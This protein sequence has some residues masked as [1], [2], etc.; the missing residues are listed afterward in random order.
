MNL[1][2]IF[3]F[4]ATA[5][6]AVNII[7]TTAS[8]HN[9]T[10]C[11]LNHT[12]S[13]Q[14]WGLYESSIHW[15]SYQT[16]MT[17][18]CGDFTGKTF[19]T[20]ITGAVTAWDDAKFNNKDLMSMSVDNDSGCVIFLDK[21]ATQMA[22]TFGT[23]SWAVTY[24]T[25]AVDDGT[26]YNHYSTAAGNIE[27]WV[28]WTTLSGRSTNAKKHVPRHELGHVI[29]LI[30]VPSSVS[31]NGHIMCNGF[32]TQYTPPTTIS[33]EDLQGA[34]VILGQHQH[35][36]STIPYKYYDKTYCRKTCTICNARNRYKHTYKNNICMLCGYKKTS[37][38]SIGDYEND[39]A[40][41]ANDGY[42]EEGT[43]TDFEPK[44]EPEVTDV[45]FNDYTTLNPEDF[46]YNP[47][48]T[49]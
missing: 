3:A 47:A 15:S 26:Q 6:V 44:P 7:T 5:S 46:P 16:N 28:D 34:A 27:I 8:A 31:P 35:N 1:K 18:D 45:G 11:G 4:I 17:V 25:N 43:I 30:D 39:S 29:G 37:T 24:R 12:V 21:T 2:K 48:E 10:D 9:A 33:N 23:S 42:M 38:T 19:A 32:G 22:E 49:Y 40:P 14:H 13:E 20:Y 36:A 41:N